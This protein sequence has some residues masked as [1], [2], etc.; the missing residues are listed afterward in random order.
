[1]SQQ[2]QKRWSV[3]VWAWL[4][5]CSVGWAEAN[6]QIAQTMNRILGT[7]AVRSVSA[8]PVKGL[9]EVVLKSGEVIYT[10]EEATHVL[11]GSLIDL[12]TRENL[13][14]RRL[15]ELG[16]IDFSSLPLADAFVLRRGKGERVFASFEDPNCGFCKRLARE[17][18]GLDNYTQY[19]FLF[20]ILGA[21][22]QEKARRIWCAKDRA[23]AWQRWMVEGIE[24]PPPSGECDASAIARNTALGQK[25]GISGTP[26]LFLKSGARVGGFVPAAQLE[27]RLEQGGR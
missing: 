25:L 11:V 17:L 22:S 7:E 6:E 5:F 24:P 18:Q 15:E 8:T 10:N 23:A 26:T 14:E 9:Y 21:D 2:Q 4:A 16:R 1:M 12:K 19:V 13:T 3:G 20:P 27:T